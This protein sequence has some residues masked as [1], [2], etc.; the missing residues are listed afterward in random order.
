[1][2]KTLQAEAQPHRVATALAN[3]FEKL[4]RTV[5]RVA[6]ERPYHELRLKYHARCQRGKK[7]SQPWQ[8]LDDDGSER[9]VSTNPLIELAQGIRDIYTSCAAC[10]LSR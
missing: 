10:P 7:G 6:C 4:W 5:E 1:M 8:Y 2:L 3:H 9:F